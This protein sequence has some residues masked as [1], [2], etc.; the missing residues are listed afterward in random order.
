[1]HNLLLFDPGL[2]LD[3]FHHCI[4]HKTIFPLQYGF[5]IIDIVFDSFYCIEMYNLLLLSIIIVA[6]LLIK[7]IN[8]YS[9]RVYL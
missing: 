9:L 6:L 8:I 3:H 7:I 4:Y 2:F 5:V 1:M